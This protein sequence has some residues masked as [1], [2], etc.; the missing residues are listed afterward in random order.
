MSPTR[1]SWKLA[2][3]AGALLLSSQVAAAITCARTLTADVIAFD[4]PIM[5]NRLGAAN[6][7]GMMYALRRDVVNKSTLDP[8]TVTPAGAVAG[9]VMDYGND[10]HWSG[11]WGILRSYESPQ[12]NLLALP[13]TIT[14]P[15]LTAASNAAFN[16]V[17]PKTAP[18]RIFDVTAVE[19]NVALPANGNVTVQDLFPTGHVGRAPANNGRTLVYNHRT[20][21]V[22]GQ[23]VLVDNPAGGADIAVVLPTHQGP[24]HDPTALAYVLTSD[25]DRAGLLNAGAPIEPL[26]LRV[27]AGDCIQV[28]LRNGLSPAGTTDLATLSTLQGVVKRDRFGLQGSTTFQTNLIQP[29][30]VVGLHPQLVTY[31]PT[32]AN[33]VIVGQNGQAQGVA[34]PGSATTL[35]WYVGDVASTRVGGRFDLT[36]TPIEFGGV[37]L[38]PADVIKQG[39][40]SLVGTLVVER[41]GATWVENSTNLD[42]QLGTGTRATRT[43]A[44]VC[45]GGQ[46]PCTAATPGALRSL[47]VVMELRQLVAGEIE[48]RK[49]AQA[50]AAG[51]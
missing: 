4:Q 33:G 23:T 24:I 10:G 2:A 22:G 1:L 25:L 51:R 47:S 17:C 34:L 27:R 43:M 46:N 14:P 16:G 30:S 13:T 21:T 15:Q 9:Q 48:A 6:V 32:L 8:L 20:T 38:M 28:T 7:N 19:A 26:V 29:S 44:S 40:K 37:S 5:F 11:T 39:Q 3:T 42:H 12:A 41:Q 18:L 45:P 35:K 36:A 49:L 50:G 31:D